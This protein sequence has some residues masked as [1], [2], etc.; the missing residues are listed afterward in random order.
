MKVQTDVRQFMLAAGQE[1]PLYPTVPTLATRILRSKLILEEALEQI[2]AMGVQLELNTFTGGAF[3]PDALEYKEG[4]SVDLAKVADGCLD[5]IYVTCG[6]ALAFGISLDHSWDLV[7][8]ANM[9]K[10]GPGSYKRPD[11]KVQ[12]PPGWIA[13]DADINDDIRRQAKEGNGL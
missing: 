7:Q 4:E 8:A 2:E 11:G 9:A 10:F 6:A 3:R 13:P 12:K 1:L 5:Q